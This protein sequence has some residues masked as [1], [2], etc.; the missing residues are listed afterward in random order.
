MN[1]KDHV[2]AAEGLLELGLPT[3]AYEELDKLAPEDRQRA[4][5]LRMRF[6]I[7]ASVGNWDLAKAVATRLV[8]AYPDDA[9]HWLSL[10]AAANHITGK[11]EAEAVLRRATLAHSK[12]AGILYAL[13]G[14][15]SIAGR[16]DAAY[17]LLE[18]ALRIE[19]SFRL[20]AISD[21]AMKPVWDHLAS[22]R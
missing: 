7:H 18:E 10:A 12:D 13:A 9:K 20:Q 3:E 4:E 16:I 6:N 17:T 19:P 11:A 2:T 5:V 15:A 22:F 1:W 14:C 8:D 21:P